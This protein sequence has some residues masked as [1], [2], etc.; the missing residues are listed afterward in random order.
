MWAAA[1]KSH[2][3]GVMAHRTT[4][5][6]VVAFALLSSCIGVYQGAQSPGADAQGSDPIRIRTVLLPDS[7]ALDPEAAA[8]IGDRLLFTQNRSFEQTLEILQVR[9]E[10]EFPRVEVF[11]TI[12]RSSTFQWIASISGQ[13]DFFCFYGLVADPQNRYRLGCFKDGET[14]V[15]PFAT[16]PNDSHIFEQPHFSPITGRIHFMA[17]SSS[18]EFRF[19]ET[20]GGQVYESSLLTPGFSFESNLS[21]DP[22]EN[23][24]TEV[25]AGILMVND[26]VRLA[27][28]SL[29]SGVASARVV[30]ALEGCRWMGNAHPEAWFHCRQTADYRVL[31]ADGT[32]ET[33]GS[34]GISTHPHPSWSFRRHTQALGDGTLLYQGS[35]GIVRF[36]PSTLSTEY[37]RILDETGSLRT[38]TM[39]FRHQRCG[40]AYFSW[41]NF[42]DPD[43]FA[44]FRIDVGGVRGWSGGALDEGPG[45]AFHH[46]CLG[47]NYVVYSDPQS[48]GMRRIVA[49]GARGATQALLSES[50]STSRRQ[51]V[52]FSDPKVWIVRTEAVGDQPDENQIALLISTQ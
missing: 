16:Y 38:G 46:G 41:E 31:L 14:R 22:E 52:V 20:D 11:T 51:S 37:I 12:P 36:D 27:R 33:R 1:R 17:R 3:L 34:A 50:D 45:S 40:N 39:G 23:L 5:S 7:S 10:Q 19:Y 49:Y 13:I 32:V 8:V 18:G 48:E 21:G 28:H 24:I 15:L 35:T 29:R 47:S 42:S 25:P 6:F 43:G 2:R 4:L 44:L 26:P 9:L 30:Q